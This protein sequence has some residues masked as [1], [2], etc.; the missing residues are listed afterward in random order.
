M[1]RVH[2]YV[3]HYLSVPILTFSQPDQ[4]HQGRR[5]NRDA[6]THQGRGGDNRGGRSR[7]VIVLV[8]MSFVLFL[9]SFVSVF[10]SFFAFRFSLRKEVAGGGDHEARQ[11][12]GVHPRIVPVPDETVAASPA[13]AEKC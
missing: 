9:L 12:E 3:I 8:G 5:F 11:G 7:G 13:F 2:Q 1:S 4:G 10:F 6:D